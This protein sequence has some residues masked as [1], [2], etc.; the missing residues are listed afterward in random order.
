M[1]LTNKEK[2][3]SLL[4]LLVVL[5]LISLVSIFTA[6]NI[7]KSLQ[8]MQLKSLTR[9]IANS[10]RTSRLHAIKEGTQKVW[11][12]NLT[13]H[14]YQMAEGEKKVAFNPDTNVKLLTISSELKSE[15][16]GGIRFFMDGSSSG[17]EITI[18]RGKFSY[19]VQVDWL[20]GL[21]KIY[22]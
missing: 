7:S 11:S 2:A 17:G 22:E 20:T 14:F 6:P 18:Q 3:F 1:P 12:I 5:S 10:M 9:D 19:S 4:E 15:K 13:D 8:H 16:Q 21:V